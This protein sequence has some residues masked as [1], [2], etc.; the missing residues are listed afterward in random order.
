MPFTH[1]GDYN[2]RPAAR[3]TPLNSLIEARP[4]L[5]SHEM[6]N[7]VDNGPASSD[8]DTLISS[9]GTLPHSRVCFAALLRKYDV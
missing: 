7:T 5:S 3:P 1:P 6:S 8:T 9:P 4:K 2:S